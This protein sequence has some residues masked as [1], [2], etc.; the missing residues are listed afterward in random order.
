MRVAVVVS[1]EVIVD[2][3]TTVDVD[4]IDF[5]AVPPPT[6]YDSVNALGV[7]LRDDQRHF[8]LVLSDEIVDAVM[9]VLQ[10]DYGRDGALLVEARDL[11]ADM[12]RVNGG[13]RVTP[14]SLIQLSDSTPNSVAMA[15]RAACSRE[16][17]DPR[18][19]VVVT[20]QDTPAALRT[21]APRGIANH[22]DSQGAVLTPRE[23]GRLVEEAIRKRRGI[24]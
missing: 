24:L 18:A 8:F 16:L 12:S 17:E 3:L 6:A 14:N 23:F 7:F 11:L 2:A 15:C 19:V 1:P 4:L 21:G 10:R 22:P 5:P 9:G 20:T 13:G